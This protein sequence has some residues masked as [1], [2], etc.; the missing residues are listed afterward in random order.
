MTNADLSVRAAIATLDMPWHACGDI[1][2]KI[3][4]DAPGPRRTAIVHAPAG[5]RLPLAGV[6]LDALNLT[7]GQYLRRTTRELACETEGT[8]FLKERPSRDRSSLQVDLHGVHFRPHDTPG[9]SVATLHES[10]DMRV[11]LLRFDAGAY[12]GAHVHA[13]GEEFFVLD[14][15]VTDELGTYTAGAWVR[16]P[17]GSAHSIESRT[18]CLFLTFADH[19]G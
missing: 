18:G 14:G 16:Q 15:E 1:L 10:V 8:W 4:E 2:E 9:L 13:R 12:I 7:T 17:P 11:V 19:L 6:C 3:L 5:A